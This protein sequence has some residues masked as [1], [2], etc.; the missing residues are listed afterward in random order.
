VAGSSAAAPNVSY[1][2]MG[3]PAPGNNPT[4]TYEAAEWTDLNVNFWIFGGVDILYKN[5]NTL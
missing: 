4:G 2:T 5:M 3:I 1:G